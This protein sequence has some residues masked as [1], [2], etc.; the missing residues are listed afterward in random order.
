MKHHTGR[1]G[2]AL[3]ENCVVLLGVLVAL[4]GAI[5]M[6]RFLLFYSTL[7][8]GARAG[9]RYAAVHGSNRKDCP[10]CSPDNAADGPSGPGNTGNV[11]GVVQTVTAAAG[12]LN[13]ALTVTVA[14]PDGDNSVNKRV[15]V[16]AAYAYA[17]M[18]QLIP[19]TPNPVTISSTS[20]GT[21]S[22]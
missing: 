7:A 16:T 20:E 8:E 1:S 11:A 14:Y 2:Q 9:M 3:I 19:F 6:G 4:L 18:V 5:E 22:Y 12:M 21:I 17:P 10:V 13:S 15:Q